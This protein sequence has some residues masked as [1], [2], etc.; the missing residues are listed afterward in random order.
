M[1]TFASKPTTTRTIRIS[2]ENDLTLEREAERNGVSVNTLI[3]NLISRYVDSIRFYDSSNMIAIGSDTIMAFMENLSD[4]EIFETAYQRGKMRIRDSL[5]QRGMNINYNSVLWFISQVL[6][7]YNGWYR[8]DHNLTDT[9]ERLH[10]SHK[11]GYKWSV[12][13]DGYLSAIFQEVLKRKINSVIS[14][15]AVNIEVLKRS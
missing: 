15:Q 5:L 11:N 14:E 9:S 4:E 7:I 13:L 6:G 12:F 2:Q 3:S 1:F 8:C 10:F